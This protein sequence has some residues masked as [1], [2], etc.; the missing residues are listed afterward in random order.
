MET[1]VI[2]NKLK[3]YKFLSKLLFVYNRRQ[4]ERGNRFNY[5]TR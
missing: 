4:E 3:I 2:T 1:N 5:L